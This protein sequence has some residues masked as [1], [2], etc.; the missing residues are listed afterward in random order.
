MAKPL[1]EEGRTMVG[2]GLS[3]QMGKRRGQRGKNP[4][5]G[6]NEDS[7]DP[8]NGAGNSRFQTGKGS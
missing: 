5:I 8:G 1:P 3:E 4:G 2:Q 7:R 6:P